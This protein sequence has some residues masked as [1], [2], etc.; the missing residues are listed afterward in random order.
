[1]EFEVLSFGSTRA[2][3]LSYAPDMRTANV[4]AS[5]LFVMPIGAGCEGTEPMENVPGEFGDP[6]T[7][8]ALEGTPD[9]CAEG[10]KCYQGYCEETCTDDTDC[11]LVEG[12]EHTCVAGLCQILC[13][14]DLEC[15]QDLGTPLECESVG[16]S[17][18][19]EAVDDE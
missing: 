7:P 19:C 11:Q 13:S 3:A 6:C 4:L 10:G 2:C 9:G 5:L 16:V 17:N 14:Q 8:G 12:W 1:M 15:P 18:I